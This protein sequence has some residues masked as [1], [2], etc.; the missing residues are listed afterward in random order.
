MKLGTDRI[1]RVL[2]GLNNPQDQVKTLHVVGT[3]GKGSTSAMLASIYTAAG[4]KTGLFTSPHLINIRERIQCQTTSIPEEEFL[5]AAE[6]VYA[7]MVDVLPDSTDWLTYF[8]FL[9]A[10][11]FWCF[12]RQ[13]VDI[14][15]IETGLGGRLDSTNV[16]ARPEAVLV[17]PISLDHI[18]RL[19]PTVTDIARE[20]SGVFKPDVPIFTGS[21]S[22]EVLRVL[23]QES[24]RVEASLYQIDDNRFEAGPLIEADQQRY[25]L[26][27]D[28]NTGQTLYLNL[29]GRYQVQNLA[30]VLSVIH[31]LQSRLPV[32]PNAVEAGLK[33]V[34][35]PARFQYFPQERL[36][37]DGSHN[38]AGFQSLLETLALDFPDANIH[39]GIT[40]LNNRPMEA[41]LP[42]VN[43]TQTASIHFLQG[44]PRERFHSPS[45]FANLPLPPVPIDVDET[46]EAFYTLSASPTDLK[47]VTGSLYTAGSVLSRFATI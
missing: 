36:I 26:V 19:G 34:H 42:L 21:Q 30:L 1:R 20:K 10:M 44:E 4:Y 39:W 40:L 24:Q 35:W 13:G 8:E 22:S 37:I 17:T 14:A 25:R 7:A 38:P 15:I 3:N 47:I 16:L 27:S 43:A 5:Q 28:M 46:P 18:E 33:R 2:A 29:L 9:N 23:T 11:A 6:A 31:H 12:A 45:A 41:V 32:S